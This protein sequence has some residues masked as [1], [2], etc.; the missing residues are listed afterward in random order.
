MSLKDDMTQLNVH[1]VT[2]AWSNSSVG[3]VTS[4]VGENSV[5]TPAIFLCPVL[6]QVEKF[7]LF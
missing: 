3:R 7:K 2:R 5:R 1:F 6:A 4:T